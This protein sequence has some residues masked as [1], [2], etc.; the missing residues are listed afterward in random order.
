MHLKIKRCDGEIINIE[1]RTRSCRNSFIW[2][3]FFSM[4]GIQRNLFYALQTLENQV[5]SEGVLC[6]ADI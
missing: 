6:F 1:K 2:R 3:Y 4:R 5:L